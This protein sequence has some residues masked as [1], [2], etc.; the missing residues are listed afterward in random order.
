MGKSKNVDLVMGTRGETENKDITFGSNTLQ[1]IKYVNCPVLAVPSV[2]GKTTPQN[3]L[4]LV[5]CCL[6][7]LEN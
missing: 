2:Y 3:L 7:N 1:V 5:I 6:T 4:F